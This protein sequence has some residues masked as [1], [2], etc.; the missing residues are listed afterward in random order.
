VRILPLV[1]LSCSVAAC[2][3]G[4]DEATDGT[5]GASVVSIERGL[6]G[7]RGVAASS[8]PAN[9][10]YVLTTFG[11]PGD[12]QAMSCGGY[13]NGTTWYAA[14]RQRYGCGSKL[15]VQANGKCVVVVSDDY[16][17]DVCV[18]NAA[19][20]PILDVSPKVSRELFNQA[21]AGWSDHMTVT[22]EEVDAATPVGICA[23][24]PTSGGGGGGGGGMTVATTCASPTLDRDVTEGTCVQ[25]AASATWQQC[26]AGAW[27]TRSGTSGCTA[28]YGFCDSAT[29]GEAVPP[30][31]C[32]QARSNSVWYQ[33]NGQSWV[34]PVSVSAKTGPIG[35][36]ATMNPL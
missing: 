30:R 17:P 3:V 25:S 21:G 7:C 33:C 24:T 4:E 11:G 22:V 2:M 36:C 20:M 31:T 27:V 1:L 32:V 13:A 5:A 28:S 16:G 9:G 34:T 18:E 10:R 12:H 15:K 29:L 26:T 35:D 23:T 14:S 8:I 19:G 6:T